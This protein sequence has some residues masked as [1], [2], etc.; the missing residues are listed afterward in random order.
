MVSGFEG[1]GPATAEYM[2]PFVDPKRGLQQP[3]PQRC[4]QQLEPCF[5]WVRAGLGI[6][7]CARGVAIAV[8]NVSGVLLESACLESPEE[9]KVR[10][11]K[12]GRIPTR[13][14]QVA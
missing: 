9:E 14:P 3:T 2:G 8:Q 10:T 11:N 12:E 13:P 4:L 6:L 7:S 5:C 1:Y